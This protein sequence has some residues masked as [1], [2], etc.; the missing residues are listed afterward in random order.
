[1]IPY[2]E[3]LNILF[4][5]NLHHICKIITVKIRCSLICKSH[6]ESLIVVLNY[7]K[8]AIYAALMVL[9]QVFILKFKIIRWQFIR[10]NFLVAVHRFQIFKFIFTWTKWFEICV[11]KSI[12]DYFWINASI[13]RLNLTHVIAAWDW[14][15]RVTLFCR[16]TGICVISVEILRVVSFVV[17]W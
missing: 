5:I 7:S 10:S 16:D 6:T 17:R 9:V 15:T 14:S 1:M 13:P 11:L 3:L 12:R 8:L 4:W 2:H